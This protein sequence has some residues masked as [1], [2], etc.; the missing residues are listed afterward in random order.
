M[1]VE[2]RKH[3]G[4]TQADLALRLG[5]P[6]SYVSKYERGERRLDFVEFL[7]VADAIDLD[8]DEFLMVFRN[9]ATKY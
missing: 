2:V 8:L 7:A 4:I 3:K 1:L 9:R 6:Q 5:K